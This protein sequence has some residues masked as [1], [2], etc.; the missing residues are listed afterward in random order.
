MSFQ[1]MLN[2]KNFRDA[3]TSN[4]NIVDIN[5]LSD[6]VNRL[7]ETATLV[8]L[9]NETRWDVHIDFLFKIVVEE[10]VVNVQL[11]NWPTTNG[12]QSQNNADGGRFDN[13]REGL[14]LTVRAIFELVDR[15]TTNG[16]DGGWALC[17]KPIFIELKSE[18]SSS[19]M[20]SRQCLCVSTSQ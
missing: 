5:Q 15:F 4:N 12:G 1:S 17:Q 20:A 16:L 7:Q 2:N 9:G 18:T 14:N 10:G 13:G 19:S 11:L 8:G 3:I 6:T